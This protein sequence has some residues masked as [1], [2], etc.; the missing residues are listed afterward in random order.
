MP[1]PTSLLRVK[2]PQIE[3]ISNR[4]SKHYSQHFCK[5]KHTVTHQWDEPERARPLMLVNVCDHTPEMVHFVLDCSVCDSL[6]FFGEQIFLYNITGFGIIQ[7][8]DSSEMWVYRRGV[9]ALDTLLT[10][11]TYPEQAPNTAYTIFYRKEV[12][13]GGPCCI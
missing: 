2:A 1:C 10:E 5:L 3:C 13:G 9:V 6:A 8:S 7:V 12:E 11:A 4:Y